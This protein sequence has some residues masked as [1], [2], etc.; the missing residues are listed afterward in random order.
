M[1][2]LTEAQ[3]RHFR[4]PSDRRTYLDRAANLGLISRELA[5]RR[6]ARLNRQASENYERSRQKE[7]G[8]KGRKQRRSR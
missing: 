6:I 1:P 5:D 8:R 2:T 7:L 3:R 4:R